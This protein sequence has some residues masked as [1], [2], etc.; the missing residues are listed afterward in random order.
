A[1]FE[2][3]GYGGSTS[4]PNSVTLAIEPEVGKVDPA[5]WQCIY[6]EQDADDSLCTTEVMKQGEVIQQLGK[7][8]FDDTKDDD[9]AEF[10]LAG[11][12][13]RALADT[14]Q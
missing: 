10:I 7:L 5:K 12:E 4:K 11:I 14:R 8:L 6:A 1:S 13:R 3:G 2:I 9:L